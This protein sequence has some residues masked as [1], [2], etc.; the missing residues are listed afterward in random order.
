[1]FGFLKSKPIKLE[2]EGMTCG[3][4]VKGVE[5]ALASVEGVKKV[6]V[7][8]ENKAA[9]VFGKDIEIPLLLKA[10]EDKGFSGRAER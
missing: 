4:C 7:S 3:G 2:V 1:M 9:E 8:L 6:D 5:R 10:L